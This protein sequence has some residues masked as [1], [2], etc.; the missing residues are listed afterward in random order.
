MCRDVV[1]LHPQKEMFIKMRKSEAAKLYT[2]GIWRKNILL[3]V[4][5]GNKKY[6]FC[7]L[8]HLHR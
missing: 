4:T 3:D 5:R 2:K 1:T 7:G 8:S 6:V